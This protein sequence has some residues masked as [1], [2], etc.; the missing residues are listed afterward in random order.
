[1]QPAPEWEE[2]HELWR[3]SED[4]RL[5]IAKEYKKSV[6]SDEREQRAASQAQQEL[7]RD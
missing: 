3:R 6:K 4:L 5:G 1:M 7:V 2:T